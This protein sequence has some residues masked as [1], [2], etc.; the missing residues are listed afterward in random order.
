MQMF[1]LTPTF[2]YPMWKGNKL[3]KWSVAG[4]WLIF[5]VVTPT[6]IT[7]QYNL[8]INEIILK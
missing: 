7:A 5:S 6:V 3:V 8:P 4:F 2:L 1:I